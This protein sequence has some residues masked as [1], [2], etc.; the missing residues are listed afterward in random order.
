MASASWARRGMS[1]TGSGGCCIKES[2]RSAICAARSPISSRSLFN[3]LVAG[4][5]GSARATRPY[6]PARRCCCGGPILP[7]HP[8]PAAGSADPRVADRSGA[9]YPRNETVTELRAARL[10]AT[11]SNLI[12]SRARA[13]PDLLENMLQLPT[14]RPRL[15]EPSWYSGVVVAVH[16][17]GDHWVRQSSRLKTTQRDRMQPDV[18]VN[19]KKTAFRPDE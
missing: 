4:S 6:R 8:F 9:K 10:Q 11:E 13:C 15:A 7:A 12:E 3:F 5:K 18:T 1:K 2:A 14:H 19:R 17:S 16:R